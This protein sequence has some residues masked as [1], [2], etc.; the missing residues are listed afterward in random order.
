MRFID[1]SG[2]RFGRLVVIERVENSKDNRTQWLCK[3]DCGNTKVVQSCH[4][5]RGDIVSC[6]CYAK[7]QRLLGTTKHGFARTKLNYI[8]DHMVARCYSPKDK[9][10]KN[11]GG[12]GIKVCDEWKNDSRTF[13]CWAIENGYDED[14][15]YMKCTLDRIDVNGDYSPENCRFVDIKTQ[16]NNRTSNHLITYN[17]ETHNLVGWEEITG[18]KRATIAHRLKLGWTVEEALTRPLCKNQYDRQRIGQ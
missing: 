18:I 17:G 1:L 7:E 9:Y 13:Y 15:P 11:Y 12:R 3:C 6:G 5:R 16:C 2:Q 8:Y 14:A 4:L 10:Y